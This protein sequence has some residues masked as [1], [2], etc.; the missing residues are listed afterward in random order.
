MRAAATN[1]LPAVRVRALFA[2]QVLPAIAALRGGARGA[3]MRAGLV[4]SQIM[5]FA[6]CRYVLELPP[7]VRMT[8]A[9]IVRWLAPTVQRYLFDRG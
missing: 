4:A 7:I 1:E 5:G 6:L 8:R 3:A 9:D 2:D